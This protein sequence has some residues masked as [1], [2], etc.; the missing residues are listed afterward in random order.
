MGDS[1]ST[2]GSQHILQIEGP[3][4][5]LSNPYVGSYK[6]PAWDSLGDK[7]IGL[8]SRSHQNFMVSV[9]VKEVLQS[10]EL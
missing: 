5:M 2:N 10:R 4:V 6:Q 3:N 8:C 7:D 9:C 1:L